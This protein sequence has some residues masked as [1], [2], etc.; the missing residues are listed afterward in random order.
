MSRLFLYQKLCC[1]KVKLRKSIF[2]DICVTHKIYTLSGEENKAKPKTHYG[3]MEKRFSHFA[4]AGKYT[5]KYIRFL[6]IFNFGM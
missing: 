6:F 4:V 1:G 3:E 2:Y 5:V